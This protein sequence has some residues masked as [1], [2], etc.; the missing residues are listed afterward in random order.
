[1]REGA[2]KRATKETDIAVSLNL[3]GTGLATV[4][5]GIG[6]LDHMLESFAKHGGFD[7]EVRASGDLHID[8]HHTVEDVGICIGAA[9]K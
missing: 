9:V 4:A 1:M 3:D 7:L 2:I 5:T 6:F 8:M